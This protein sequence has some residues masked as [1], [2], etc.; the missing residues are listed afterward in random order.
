MKKLFLTRNKKKYLIL[1][2][3]L[4]LPFMGRSQADLHK[5]FSLEASWLRLGIAYEQP[6]FKNT[7]AELSAGV[8]DF[9]NQEKGYS[10]NSLNEKFSPYTKASFRYYY[11]RNKRER[12]G[13]DNSFNRGNFIAFQ[14][15]ILYGAISDNDVRMINEIHWGVRTVIVKKLLLTLHV[16]IGHYYRK[17]Y[18]KEWNSNSKYLAFA[19]TLG[20]EIKYILF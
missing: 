6:L 20:A 15:K 17:S 4:A 18:V 3:F 14:N 11:N 8:G 7:E 10:I 9:F 2:I 19:P 13:K 16:G 1:T 5:Q 12:K